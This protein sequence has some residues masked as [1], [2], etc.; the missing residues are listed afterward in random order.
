MDTTNDY[1][2]L[3]NVRCSGVV[4]HY[5]GIT[6]RLYTA[7]VTY[8]N[9]EGDAL[10]SELI[11]R[12]YIRYYDANGLLRTYHNNYTGTACFGGCRTS[13]SAIA[14]IISSGQVY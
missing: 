1:A 14:E 10:A 7:V 4:D 11:A 3:K 9:A 2:Y 13:Y 12:S 8:K 5:E 6:Y